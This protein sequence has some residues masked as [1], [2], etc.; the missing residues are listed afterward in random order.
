MGNAV[1]HLVLQLQ[2]VLQFAVI[3]AGPEVLVRVGPNQLNTDANLVTRA[4]HRAFNER[5]DVEFLANRR[6]RL[7]RALEAHHGSARNYTEIV[8]R[9]KP[10]NQC[11]GHAVREVVLFGIAGKVFERKNGERADACAATGGRGGSRAHEPRKA[12]GQDHQQSDC[13]SPQYNCRRTTCKPGG[14]GHGIRIRGRGKCARNTLVAPSV[15]FPCVGVDRAE[16]AVMEAMDGQALA[17]L[18]AADGRDVTAQIG[19]DFLPSFQASR[20][21]VGVALGVGYGLDRHG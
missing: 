20:P 1:S 19:G 8:N 15:Q 12:R 17:L 10:R 11:L 5:I 13:Q 16:L 6:Q 7:S 3:G 9:R 2:H 18:P 4:H 21:G 14:G